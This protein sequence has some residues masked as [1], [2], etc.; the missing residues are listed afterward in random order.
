MSQATPEELEN[1]RNG[2]FPHQKKEF[3]TEFPNPQF[4]KIKAQFKI[5]NRSRV[6]QCLVFWT[7]REGAVEIARQYFDDFVKDRKNFSYS[8]VSVLREE[9]LFFA[10]KPKRDL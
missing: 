6:F 1:A 2:I 9:Y 10:D 5:D 3:E 7:S 8:I 4:Y